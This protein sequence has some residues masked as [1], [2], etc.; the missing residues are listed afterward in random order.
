M[1]QQLYHGGST[2]SAHT[3]SVHKGSLLLA[4]ALPRGDLLFFATLTTLLAGYILV[5]IWES[6]PAPTKALALPW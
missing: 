5:N 1:K 6:Y 3:T 4:T 2:L